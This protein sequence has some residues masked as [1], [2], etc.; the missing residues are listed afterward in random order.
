M[1]L[2]NLRPRTLGFITATLWLSAVVL[3]ILHIY[4]V[5]GSVPGVSKSLLSVL[6]FVCALPF[7]LWIG[8]Y[9]LPQILLLPL[10]F[11][12]W[13]GKRAEQRRRERQR[14]EFLRMLESPFLRGTGLHPANRRK[15]QETTQPPTP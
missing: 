6:T 10:R 1:R 3:N 8:W 2:P 7:L 14:R 12:L 15:P 11:F 9:A 5:G 13:C 4:G